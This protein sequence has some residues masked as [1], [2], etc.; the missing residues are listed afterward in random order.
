MKETSDRGGRFLLM[1]ADLGSKTISRRKFGTYEEAR[2]A[3]INEMVGMGAEMKDFIDK[4]RIGIGAWN[5]FLSNKSG[6]R[7]WMIFDLSKN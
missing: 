4:N 6:Y 7:E 2:E 5:A 3:M 1:V